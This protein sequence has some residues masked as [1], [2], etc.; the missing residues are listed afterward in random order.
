MSRNTTHGDR[1]P[2]GVR[3][4]GTGQALV[5][6]GDTRLRVL[7]DE[8]ARFDALLAR[9]SAGF[10]HLPANAVDGQ[11]ERALRQIVE[12]LGI[13][14][15]SLAQF[16]P[17]GSRL[18]VTHSYTVPGVAR[19][20]AMDLAAEW[21][22][23]TAQVRRAS[24][25]RFTRLPEE[26]PVEAVGERA[27]YLR[28]GGPRSH[29]AVPFEV[30]GAVLGVIGFGSFCR[31]ID[32]PDELVQGLQLLSDVFANALARKWADIALRE[33]E[34]RFRRMTDTAPVMVWMSGP[35]KLCTYFNQRW[36]DFTGRPLEREVGDGWSEGVH[37]DDLRHCLDTYL[38][39]FDAR[40]DFR[41]EYRLRR[42]DGEY[43][44]VLDTGT[45]RFGSDSTFEGYIGSAI[46]VTEQKRAEEEEARLRGQLTR[47]ARVTL[48]GELAASIAHEV[49]QPLCAI[50]NNAEAVQCLLG[51]EPLDV[52]EVRGALQDIM[53][54]GRRASAVI[55][56]IR[57]SLQKKPPER[58]PVDVNDLIHEAA[59]LARSR[60]AGVGLAP[61][62]DLA[63]DLPPVLGDRVQLLQVLL[64]LLTNAADAMEGAAGGAGALVVRSAADGAG[65]VTVAVQDAGRGIGLADAEHVFDALFTTKLAGMGMGL[66]ICRSI[67]Q[68]HGGKIAARANA[69]AGT[70]FECT[71][72]ALQEAAP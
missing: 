18:L 2:D 20:A 30:G 27:Y 25:L 9:L 51:R 26:L 24:V 39:A 69:D 8:R 49:D 29:L 72:P 45:P 52:E 48:L 58:A 37:P 7:L 47:V 21:P 36:L 6:E 54:D 33:S 4:N 42:F 55:A 13:E 28:V 70:T 16:T 66:A 59:A 53:Q 17:D 22:W 19:L 32:W 35:D 46:D 10:I 23:Y 62:L 60:L 12:L 50:V 67:I 56:R 64:N 61:R 63:A 41:M 38:Q 31:P 34:N 1:A 3:S 40:Q 15:S 14:R 68:A 57:A 44:W 11:I 43:R 71:R 5:G 65:G